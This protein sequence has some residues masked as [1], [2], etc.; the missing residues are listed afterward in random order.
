MSMHLTEER[1]ND[2]V[3]G[4]LSATERAEVERHLEG[5]AECRAEV[6]GLRELL[7]EVATLP[8]EITPPEELWVGVKEETVE[9]P[10]RRRETL[11]GMR[12][13]LAAAAVVL[14]ALSSALTTAL[15]REPGAGEKAAPATLPVATAGRAPAA[16]APVPAALVAFREAETE[17][18]RTAADLEA[19]LR[20]GE[21]RLSPGTVKVVEENLRIIDQ[22]IGEARAALEADPASAELPILLS[23]M[24]RNKIDVLERAVRLSAQT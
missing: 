8:L 11:W 14:V 5:C 24:Y 23:S 16:D 7:Y 6:A 3:D 4:E 2:Y 10:V 21:G 15:L 19:V 22:A 9:L 1:L 13:G 17:Y 18:V 12:Y 20:A